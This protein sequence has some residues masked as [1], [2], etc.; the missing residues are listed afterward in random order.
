MGAR[1]RLA[2]LGAPLAALAAL[3]S[4]L[5]A[6]AAPTTTTTLGDARHSLIIGLPGPLTGCTFLD[7]GAS[8]SDLALLDLIRPSAFWTNP[9]GNLSGEGGAIASAELTSIGPERVVYTLTP[10]LRWSNGAP[11]TGS[12]LIAWW[13][14]ARTVASVLSDGYRDISSMSLS[15]GGTAVT[16]TFSHPDAEWP[17]LFRD[18]EAPGTAT[19]C[20]VDQIARRPSL[21][22]YRVVSASA[23]RVELVANAAWPL[24]GARFGRVIVEVGSPLPTRI[25]TPFANYVANVTRDAVTSLSAHPAVQSHL[26]SSLAVTQ[27]YLSPQRPLTA[28]LAGREAL[29]WALNR[30]DLINNVWGGVTLSPA[31]GASSLFSQGQNS[32]PTGSPT[33]TT[34][35]TAPGG[36]PT[37]ADC[38]T[39]ASAAMRSLGYRR[40]AGRWRDARGRAVSLTLGRGPSAID[41]ATADEVA[42]QWRGFGLVVRVVGFGADALAAEAAAAHR[43]DGAVVTRP[44]APTPSVAARAYAGPAYYDTYPSGWR[45]ADTSRLYGAALANFN[46][47]SALTTWLVL[48]QA[49]MS[50]FWVRPLF[51]WPSLVEW[52]PSLNGVSGA[53]SVA[54]FVDEVTGF[55]S[56]PTPGS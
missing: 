50:R 54:A 6:G 37:L 16:A 53:L 46:A 17:E 31:V 23:T 38:P 25:T 55:S 9:N 5:P 48:D 21:G 40:Q 4:V 11:F 19:G 35:T 29:A 34:S 8:P 52:S 24:D 30:Q 22:P 42:S 56:I 41:R 1:R 3:V 20:G 51:T 13:H 28:P 10:H 39:C 44:I 27:L 7:R 14:R 15:Q 26:G 47:A 32:Y 36:A 18:V 45:A 12:D 33:G 43:V 2:R 49:V